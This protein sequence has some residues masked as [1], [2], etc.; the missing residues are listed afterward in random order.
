MTMTEP[1]EPTENVGAAPVE[2]LPTRATYAP[3]EA[4]RVEVRGG[5]PDGRLT[6]WSLGDLVASVPV[7]GP[8]DVDLGVLPVGTYGVELTVADG[9]SPLARTA[10]EITADVRSRLRYGFVADYAPRRDVLSSL[11]C[12]QGR[13]AE[14]REGDLDGAVAVGFYLADFGGGGMVGV[15]EAEVK[16]AAGGEAFERC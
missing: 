16:P 4:V 1:T 10:V 2:L 8:G 7:G 14:R 15:P 12:R 9:P 13:D 5:V 3:T 6:V 11:F